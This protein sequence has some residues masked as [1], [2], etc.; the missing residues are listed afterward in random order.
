[1][2]LQL[3]VEH[4]FLQVGVELG[5]CWIL[6][7]RY[8][9]DVMDHV[10]HMNFLQVD[11]WNPFLCLYIHKEDFSSINISSNNEGEDV[12]IIAMT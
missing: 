10:I 4:D 3:E 2:L 11:Q 6:K 7:L 12:L 1:M 9:V 8:L 5:F